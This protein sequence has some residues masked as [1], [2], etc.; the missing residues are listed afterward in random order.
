[1]KRLFLLFA[2]TTFFLCGNDACGQTREKI[3][4]KDGYEWYK[5]RSGS[6][7]GAQ[8]IEGRTIIPTQYSFICY[9]EG[10]DGFFTVENN[11]EHEGAYEKNGKCTISPSR[12]YSSVCKHKEGNGYWYSVK[13]GGKEGACD[14]NGNEI[15]VPKYKLIFYSTVDN[16][17]KYEDS[18]GKNVS[19]GI[20]LKS[21]SYASS[22]NSSSSSSS[23]SGT[24]L[25]DRSND[26]LIETKKTES[27][28]F[29]WYE[30]YKDG[31][32]GVQKSDGTTLIPPEFGLIS[33]WRPINSVEGRFIVYDS[34]LKHKGMY[35]KDGEC[36]IPLS[37][38][39]TSI[40]LYGGNDDALYYRVD[41]GE[42]K[43]ACDLNGRVIIAPQYKAIFLT[44]GYFKYED[45]NGRTVNT[46]IKYTGTPPKSSS[47]YASS[48]SSSSTS[49][50]ASTSHGALHQGVYTHG[51]VGRSNTGHTITVPQQLLNIDFYQDHIM[52][53]GNKAIYSGEMVIPSNAKNIKLPPGCRV[54]WYQH[55]VEDFNV[56]YMVDANYNMEALWVQPKTNINYFFP[57]DKGNTMSSGSAGGY[58]GGSYNGGYNG[59][60]YSGNNSGGGSTPRQLYTKTCGVC[61]GTGTCNTC[62]G[63]GVVSALGMGKDHY[64]TSCRNHDGRCSSCGGKGTWKE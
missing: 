20:S 16:V 51:S 41:K 21:S 46:G 3:V 1:M 58:S 35:E 56:I 4:E 17:F 47:S 54:K 31:K 14:A 8:S 7:R 27:D 13:K 5:V 18:N 42:L 64:C 40:G 38:E 62:G 37:R 28:G 36:V 33:Y 6:Y 32:Y 50:S 55:K 24:V 61:H 57:I 34:G 11:E 29:T 52:V 45:A 10:A 12:G 9:H 23:N 2:I 15:I 22:S 44:Y 63:R 59:G 53:N 48:S 49:S 39:Y 43:G 60:S 25:S 26:G 30:I 19:T